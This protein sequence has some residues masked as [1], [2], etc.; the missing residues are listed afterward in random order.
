VRTKALSVVVLVALVAAVPVTGAPAG[1]STG[2]KVIGT[3]SVPNTGSVVSFAGSLWVTD[4]QT[5]T[6]SRIEPTTKRVIASIPVGNGGTQLTGGAGSVWV[7]NSDDSTVS[8]VDPATNSV[9]A[10][11]PVGANPQGITAT[12]G[13]VWVASHDG[14]VTK[15][16]TATNNV[17]DTI[18]IGGAA[19]FT[20]AGDGSVWVGV[21]RQA[22]GLVRID[23]TTDRV[24]AKI[25]LPTGACGGIAVTP[26]AVWVAGACSLGLSRVD[27]ASDSVVDTIATTD[28]VAF[29]A[30]AFGSLWYTDIPTGSLVRVD[31]ATDAV[32]GRLQ[33]GGEQAALWIAADSKY[34][35]VADDADD[36]VFQLKPL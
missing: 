21:F 12:P 25:S 9:V 24:T 15:I 1:D 19:L 32:V 33:L 7:A 16:D 26:T 20:T 3:I 14:T 35:W 23:P 18:K 34:L 36:L 10:T 11:I 31:P 30:S 2:A 27:P 29:V 22:H 5:A 13:A 4:N 17:V 28:R 8:R 6:L